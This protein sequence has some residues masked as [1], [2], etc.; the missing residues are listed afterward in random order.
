MQEQPASGRPAVVT[1]VA[2]LMFIG[3]AFSLL[4]GLLTLFGGTALIGFGGGIAIV[5]GIILIGIGAAEIWVGNGLLQLRENARQF[6][7]V[8]AGV[9][10]VLTVV[11]VLSGAPSG[12]L[13]IAIDGFIIWALVT[14]KEPF[15]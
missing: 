11:N 12:I 3:G 1:A 13:A 7:I 8:L 6:G 14:N 15:S 10:L 5:F 9:S 4:G 2:V